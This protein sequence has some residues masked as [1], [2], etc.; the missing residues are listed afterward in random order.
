MDSVANYRVALLRKTN[1]FAQYTAP[2]IQTSRI[3]AITPRKSFHGEVGLRGDVATIRLCW[4]AI[5]LAAYREGEALFEPMF[6][7]HSRLNGSFA[8]PFPETEKSQNYLTLFQ[9]L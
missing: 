2:I 3:I 7:D 8:L 1:P 5:A 4:K 6:R 9:W